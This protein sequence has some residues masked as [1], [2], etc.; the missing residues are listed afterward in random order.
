MCL[1]DHGEQ[2]CLAGKI[3]CIPRPTSIKY[4][5]DLLMA[6]QVRKYGFTPLLNWLEK[7]LA[8]FETLLRCLSS[9]LLSLCTTGEIHGFVSSY[10]CL[11][12]HTEREIPNWDSKVIQDA[13][14]FTSLNSETCQENTDLLGSRAF[15]PVW[16][17]FVSGLS[18]LRETLETKLNLRPLTSN[19][20]RC[21]WL[22]E[23]LL[24]VTS[25]WH[26]INTPYY[27][28]LPP[29]NPNIEYYKLIVVGYK[30]V[31]DFCYRL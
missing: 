29:H 13:I 31:H 10:F 24:V 4:R 5:F 14:D 9:I 17:N 27:V 1:Q 25:R 12:L 19:Y 21:H 15:A 11:L 6:L 16:G 28:A 7:K 26:P 22:L 18:F 8:K 30:C 2:F 23:M 20:R 3:T